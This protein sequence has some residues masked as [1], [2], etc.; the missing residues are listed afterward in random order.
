MIDSDYISRPGPAVVAREG[1]AHAPE[2]VFLHR[3]TL[4]PR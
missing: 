4:D 3:M 2:A 1:G